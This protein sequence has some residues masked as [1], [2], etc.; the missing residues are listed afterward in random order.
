VIKKLNF[1]TATSPL[2]EKGCF[3]NGKNIVLTLIFAPT[4]QRY[5]YASRT[6]FVT[7]YVVSGRLSPTLIGLEGDSVSASACYLTE[8]SI[9][10]R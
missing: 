4:V 7:V 5:C 1:S 10:F 3:R 9:L 2:H 8:L 6:L